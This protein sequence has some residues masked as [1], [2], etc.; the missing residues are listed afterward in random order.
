MPPQSV[1]IWRQTNCLSLTLNYHQYDLPFLEPEMHNQF[2]GGGYSGKAAG[3]FPIIYYLVAKLWD[4][5][6]AHEWIYKLVQII[7]LFFGLF[8]L[9][10]GLI[11]V[12]KNQYLA[13]FV[14][15]LVFTSPMVVFYGPNYL[16]DVPS[17]SFVFIAWYF[18]IRFL[19][20]R[21]ILNLWFSALMFS[22]AMLLK[23]TAAISFIALGGWILI[24]LLFLKKDQCIFCFRW[25]DIVPFILALV[26]IVLWYVYVEQYNQNNQGLY[27]FHGI[28]PIWDMTQEQISRVIDMLDYIYFKEMY[29]PYTQYLTLAIWL[30]LIFRIRKLKPVFRYFILV[31][32]V[33]MAIQLALW[34]QVFEAHDYYMV[35]LIVVFVAVWAIFFTQLKNL[36]PPVKVAFSVLA[37]AFFL[38]NALTCR[39]RIENR[40]V[41]W[42]NDMYNRMKPLTEIEPSF[43]EWGIGPEDKVISIPDFT[44]NGSLYYM[45]RKGY[46]EYGSNID[47]EEGFYKRIEQGARFLIVNDSTILNSDYIQPFTQNKIGQYKNISAYDLRNIKPE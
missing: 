26:P 1:H 13:A 42:M 27:S 14:S 21:K 25:K 8:A 19:K 16:P 10:H 35:N 18:I 2:G 34:F 37:V 28:L 7:I 39:E 23:I 20:N 33:G 41:G 46:T 5:F 44:F 11:Y 30:F 17:L 22:L 6:G 3:E 12:L 45:N 38:W 32:P 36:R 40:Y 24:E 4:V 31:L 15:L 9:F 47:S 29:L 43:R